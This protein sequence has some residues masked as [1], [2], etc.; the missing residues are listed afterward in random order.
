MNGHRV[1]PWL[2]LMLSGNSGPTMAFHH[3]EDLSPVSTG[4]FPDFHLADSFPAL[5]PATP[6]RFL[7]TQYHA[8]LAEY[9]GR[10]GV[11]T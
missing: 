3:P 9:F 6:L 11:T 4:H 5:K 8:L 1:L 2:A 10:I 7:V